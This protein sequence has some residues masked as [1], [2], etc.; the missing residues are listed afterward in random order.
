MLK[1]TARK[2]LSSL[3]TLPFSPSQCWP[4]TAGV[5][6][7]GLTPQDTAPHSRRGNGGCG[8]GDR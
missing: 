6:G 5:P 2:D 8:P 1:T 7:T 4:A 3:K